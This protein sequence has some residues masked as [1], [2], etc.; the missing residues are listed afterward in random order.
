M[1]GKGGAVCQPAGRARRPNRRGGVV[2]G[3]RPGVDGRRR[4]PDRSASCGN[5]LHKVRWL[6]GEGPGTES[7]PAW[8]LGTWWVTACFQALTG[9]VRVSLCWPL[10]ASSRLRGLPSP[11]SLRGLCTKDP[12]PGSRIP[13]ARLPTGVHGTSA[14][15]L[16][17]AGA[18]RERDAA[19]CFG[20]GRGCLRALS[21]QAQPDKGVC[22]YTGCDPEP[23]PQKTV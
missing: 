2:D 3:E 9:G 11:Q 17:G 16:L 19:E 10:A 23:S 20:S 7:W 5:L 18:G 22:C 8:P 15:A 1:L 12:F 13:Q 14:A 4:R 6:G 21:R